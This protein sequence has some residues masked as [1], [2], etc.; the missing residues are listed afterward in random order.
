M[1]PTT[2]RLPKGTLEDVADEAENRELSRSE[3]IRKIIDERH[4]DYE[5]QLNDYKQK[6]N[7]YE[8]QVADYEREDRDYAEQ[9]TDYE[10]R[11][12][13]YEE[14]IKDLETE[15]QRLVKQLASTN[16]RIDAANDLVKYVEQQRDL[17]RYRA[18]REQMIDQAGMFTRWKWKFTGVPVNKNNDK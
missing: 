18:R 17:E 6:I 2:L 11:V 13:E 1:Q 16:Q 4:A 10:Q 5:E 7:D 8:K 15:N 14:R 3:Y 9:V 12:N